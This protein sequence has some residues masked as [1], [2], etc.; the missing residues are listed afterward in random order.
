MTWVK[1]SSI[2]VVLLGFVGLV[3]ASGTAAAAV[4]G[5]QAQRGCEFS[6]RVLW[7]VQ[8]HRLYVGC[9]QLEDAGLYRWGSEAQDT[10]TPPTVSTGSCV[11]CMQHQNHLFRTRSRPSTACSGCLAACRQEVHLHI[12]CAIPKPGQT[13][14]PVRLPP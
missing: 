13:L 9:Q 8:K 4:C 14:N 2:T 6:T 5:V 11:C 10:T 12:V 7:V 1:G 3:D